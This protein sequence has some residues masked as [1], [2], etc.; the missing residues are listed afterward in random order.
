MEG[1]RERAEELGALALL[2]ER[3]R[4]GRGG[5]LAVS[6]DPGVGK[7]SLLAAARDRARA[8]GLEVLT[9]RG[10]ALERVH[11]FGVAGQLVPRGSGLVAAPDESG[12]LATII[13]LYEAIARRSAGGAL[14]VAVD[15]VQ[16]A[17]E[18]TLRFLAHLA[19][20]IEELPVALVVALRTGEPDVP[21]EL[22]QPLLDR[23][24]LNLRP[25]S[26]AGAAAVIEEALGPDL[27]EDLVAACFRATGGNPFYLHELV[28]TIA[29]EGELPAPERVAQIVP[30]A[31]LRAT[32]VRLG[33]LPAECGKLAKGLAILG[34]GTPL[35]LA[36]ALAELEMTEAEHAADALAGARILTQGDPL[37]FAHPLI[38]SALLNDIGGFE[39]AR[40]HGRAA[41]LLLAE[42]AA[43]E[44]V[45]DHLLLTS[46]AGDA[47]R[48][49]IFAR[50]AERST[51]SGD[52]EA[53]ARLLERAL[54]EPPTAEQSPEILLSLARAEAMAGSGRATDR[55]EEALELIEDGEARARGLAE[56]AVLAHHRGEFGAAVD[57]ARRAL[58]EHPRERHGRERLIAIEL[59]AAILDPAHQDRGRAML[60]PILAGARAGRPP[61]D[62]TL[63][64]TVVAELG[65]TDPP[66][67]VLK[68]AEAATSGD[69][70]VDRS[71]GNSVGWIG[72]GLIWVDQ[73]EACERWLDRALPAA[74]ERGAVIAG[75]VAALQRAWVRY[76]RGSLDGAVADAER[77][78]EL[79]RYG[80]TSS[81]WSTPILACAYIARGDLD[82]AREALAVGSEAGPARPEYAMLLEAEARLHLA[83]L[84]PEKALAKARAA[85]EHI[86]GRYGVVQPRVWEWR[87][88]AALAAGRAGDREAGRALVAPDLEALR[89]IGPTRQLGAALTVAGLLAEPNEAVDLLGEAEAVLES[90]PS[91]LQRIETLIEL[92]GARRRAGQRTA[93]KE[94][95]YRAL[96]LAAEL[97]AGH[98][99]TRA[100]DELSA[101]GLRPRRTAR[102][103]PAS[104]T[105][106]ERRI[107]ELAAQGLTT[108]QITQA[109]HVTRNTVETHLK[110][111]YRKLE[112]SGREELSEALARTPDAA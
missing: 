63:L 110:H 36:A 90:S 112:V 103:G 58:W 21:Q 25:L 100:R 44:R 108:A 20:R 82:A 57:L 48:V 78:L 42:D 98:L 43:A 38:A 101:L 96:E 97:G 34:D 19:L 10:S 84:E 64:A 22:V 6:G 76:L 102:A 35:R 67:E 92:G 72:S 85:G 18:P 2:V 15:D 73:L 37:A 1:L 59:G 14:L 62:P 75:A 13:R 81:P 50:A 65:V 46:P 86:E 107:A 45:A 88:L 8:A 5:L 74:E 33:R 30:E 3:A 39:R 111:V 12:G 71:Y 95:L 47:R 105:P 23:A 79:Y 99:E 41:E 52:P 49:T 4:A 66:G 104:L 9:A 69:P 106:S 87:R 53:A 77:A 17:D 16:W 32:M 24:V 80:W 89:E 93:A 91:R 109:L 70:L 27:D 83:E 56:L 54:E 60:E 68:L 94:P 40:A 26:E 7:S 51:A 11:S 31:V 55:V 61:S 28:A 29:L